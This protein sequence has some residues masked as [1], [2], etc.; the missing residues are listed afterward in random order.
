MRS[1]D[2]LHR[3][4]GEALAHIRNA[5]EPRSDRGSFP[6]LQPR[7]LPGRVAD[8]ERQ[9]AAPEAVLP[10]PHSSQSHPPLPRDLAE[11]PTIEPE[12]EREQTHARALT[13]LTPS[14]DAQGIAQPERGRPGRRIAGR[15]AP[16]YPGSAV[17]PPATSA[18]PPSPAV[19]RRQAVALQDGRVVADRD[20]TTPSAPAVESPAANTEPP[21]PAETRRQASPLRPAQRAAART[22]EQAD[23][24]ETASPEPASTRAV[25]RDTNTNDTRSDDRSPE[26]RAAD[27]GADSAD[28]RPSRRFGRS[29][30]TRGR[31]REATGVHVGSLEI[32]VVQPPPPPAPPQQQPPTVVRVVAPA[33]AASAPLARGFSSTIGLR[34]G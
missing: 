3:D 28:A 33:P 7:R 27:D 24:A 15:L 30:R 1:Q 29:A 31:N 6:S 25:T 11:T 10:R 17:E 9:A 16:P 18:N 22:R 26:D 32:R 14:Q 2:T 4:A 12:R 23:S 21:L 34:Q 19:R 20:A 8:A 5:V 13:T